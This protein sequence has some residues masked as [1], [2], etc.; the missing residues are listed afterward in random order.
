MINRIWVAIKTFVHI[1]LNAYKTAV[2]LDDTVRALGNMNYNRDNA[3]TMLMTL[4]V[5]KRLIHRIYWEA[6]PQWKWRKQ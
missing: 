3:N 1:H 4:E 5:R 2:I 6:L